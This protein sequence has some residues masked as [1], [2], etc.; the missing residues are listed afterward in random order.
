MCAF[1]SSLSL[2]FSIIFTTCLC[3][4]V[5]VIIIL[6]M[7]YASVSILQTTLWGYVRSLRQFVSCF[8]HAFFF[9]YSLAL[10]L[11]C[12]YCVFDHAFRIICCVYFIILATIYFISFI[13]VF[14][15]FFLFFSSSFLFW[16]ELIT[17]QSLLICAWFVYAVC[18]RAVF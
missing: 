16:Y 15:F 13:R 7:L 6:W 2:F 4:I 3:V 1:F 5:V 14:F 11:Y 12:C 17:Q 18:V 8:F 10:C 9:S